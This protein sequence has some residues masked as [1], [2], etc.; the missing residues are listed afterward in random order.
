LYYVLYSDVFH[1]PFTLRESFL[2][3]LE[4]SFEGVFNMVNSHHDY[5]REAAI[6]A[7]CQFCIFFNDIKTPEGKVGKW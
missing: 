3:V 7:L 2:L 4:R 1:F 6:K 5:I